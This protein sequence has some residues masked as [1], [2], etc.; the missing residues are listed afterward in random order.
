MLLNLYFLP[1]Q[2]LSVEA[3]FY[4][5]LDSET[6]VDP[7]LSRAISSNPLLGLPYPV[8]PHRLPPPHLLTVTSVSHL[9]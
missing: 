3:F 4:C 2:W 6:S 7:C 5:P 1:F 9:F 8:A